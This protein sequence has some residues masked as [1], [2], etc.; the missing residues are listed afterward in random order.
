MPPRHEGERKEAFPVVPPGKY[1]AGMTPRPTSTPP[2]NG[3]SLVSVGSGT[4]PIRDRWGR[5]YV[6]RS[7]F[8]RDNFSY[9]IATLE[10]TNVGHV[11]I[12]ISGQT[13]RLAALHVA[14]EAAAWLPRP[15]RR[16]LVRLFPGWTA[17][18]HRGRGLGSLLLIYAL[19]T[20]CDLELHGVVVTDPIPATATG[21]FRNLGFDLRPD[22]PGLAARYRTS[23]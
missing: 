10:G 3:H 21:L 9:R 6:L 22:E 5:S 20:A 1:T 11:A 12:E 18:G 14:D 15:M 2:L 17:T 16:P 4:H 23:N 7:E 8:G 19:K 13:G